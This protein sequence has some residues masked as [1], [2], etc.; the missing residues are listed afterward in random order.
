MFADSI[1]PALAGLIAQL[2]E[3]GSVWTTRQRG[4]FL[5]AFGAA[6]DVL[7]EVDDIVQVR[8][9]RDEEDRTGDEN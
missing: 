2:P 1:P 4:N 5:T 6:L 8:A 7:F 3:T 9:S